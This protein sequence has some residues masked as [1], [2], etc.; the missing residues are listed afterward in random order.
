VSEERFKEIFRRL[1]SETPDP[2]AFSDL[3]THRAKPVAPIPLKPWM[4]ATGAAALVLVVVGAF[5]LLGGGGPDLAA[6]DE[7]TIDYIKLE[8][9]ATVNPVCEGGEIID[10]GGF[11]QATI[12]IWGPNSDDLTL[13]LATFPDG[14]TERVMVEGEQ[15]NP[16]Y[17]WVDGNPEDYPS[18]TNLRVVQCEGMVSPGLLDAFSP[19]SAGGIVPFHMLG[20]PPGFESFAEA[21]S[22]GPEPTP[23]EWNGNSVL[24]YEFR[25]DEEAGSNAID[26]YVTE[27]DRRA[28]RF[29]AEQN[30]PGV[31]DAVVDY[32]VVEQDEVPADSV[33]PRFDAFFGIQIVL[34]GAGAGDGGGFCSRAHSCLTSTS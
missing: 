25:R 2:P 28:L 20:P 19:G 30:L 5:G 15:G 33:S 22:P 12:E 21:F 24:L 16:D 23:T 34:F 29:H 31:G 26:L 14:S 6:P 7:N 9:S 3:E 32:S 18:N 11:D 8:Y 13:M 27:D 4:A 17:I 10:N 1:T